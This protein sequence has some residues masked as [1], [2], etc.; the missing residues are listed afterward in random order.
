MDDTI[1]REM[2]QQFFE[3]M[4]ALF[5]EP[6]VQRRKKT[7][8]ISDTFVLHGVQIVFYPDGQEPDVRLNHEVRAI[9][10]IKLKEG[11]IKQPREPIYQSEIERFDQIVLADPEDA[12]CGHATIVRINEAAWTLSFDFVYNKALSKIHLDRAE[13]FLKSAELNLVSE[14][15]PPFADN[16]F[17][18]CE[19]IAKAILLGMPDPKFRQKASHAGIQLK[20]NKFADLGNVKDDVRV[21]LNKLSGMRT[22]AR[23]L[24]GGE[25]KLAN[26]EAEEYL[27]TVR[28]M[29]QHA[30]I[31]I[32]R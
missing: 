11:V 13:A 23:Y 31:R 8:E 30:E 27:A 22:T 3:Q 18:A 10:K 16:L 19:L 1:N 15:W 26:K 24:K 12:D 29:K 25:F 32:S 2:A 7:G 9:A 20:F 17:S 5:V 14:N 28:E 21:A 4:M 6:E